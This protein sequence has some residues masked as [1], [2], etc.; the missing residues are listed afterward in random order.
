M[1]LFLYMGP[2]EV[3]LPYVVRNEFGGGAA[4]LGRVSSLAWLVSFGL[5]PVS[6]AVA[7]P[8]AE[9]VGVEETMLVAGALGALA[10]AAF[11]LLPGLR[12]PERWA[13]EGRTGAE[14]WAQAGA[15]PT[16]ER[17]TGR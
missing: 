12:D 16:A 13:R 1:V 11:L 10:T 7:G 14:I 8:L 15:Q 5:T 9:A 6:F 3:L 17:L 2:F 4:A